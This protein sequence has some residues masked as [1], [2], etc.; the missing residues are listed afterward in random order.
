MVHV[1]HIQAGLYQ[2]KASNPQISYSTNFDGSGNNSSQNEIA[3]TMGISIS[4]P[5]TFPTYIQNKYRY[6]YNAI[7]LEQ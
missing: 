5:A 3:D 6:T 4:V 2:L 1:L 7:N